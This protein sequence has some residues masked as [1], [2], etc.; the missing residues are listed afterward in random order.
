[1]QVRAL[2]FNDGGLV[3]PATAR[4][5]LGVALGY[6]AE[7]DPSLDPHIHILGHTRILGRPMWVSARFKGNCNAIYA[8]VFRLGVRNTDFELG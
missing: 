5:M 1:M 2:S 3:A 7:S 6:V 8:S 4:V